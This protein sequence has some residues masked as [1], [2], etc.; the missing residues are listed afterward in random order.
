MTNEITM[1]SEIDYDCEDFNSSK[2]P[3]MTSKV[4]EEMQR[5]QTT[6]GSKVLCK[7]CGKLLQDNCGTSHLKRHLVICPKRPKPVGVVTQDPMSPAYLRDSGLSKALMVRPLKVEPQSQVI[8]FSPTPNYGTGAVT[9]ASIDNA[10]NSIVELNHKNSPT[11]F[12][13]SL[14]SRQNQEELSLDDDVEMKAFYASLDV[15]TSFKSPSQDT[16]VITESSNTTTPSEETSKALKT[17]QDLLSKDFSVLLQTKQCGAMKSTIEYLSK[18]S[19]VK[20]IS[21]EMKLLILEV[22]REFTRWSCDYNNASKKIESASSNITKADKLEESLEANKNEF[23]E[24]LSLENEL[25]NQLA[26]LEQRKKELEDQINAIKANI[27]VFQSA[28]FTAAKR[29]RE[30]F[31]EAKTLKAQRDELREQ[32]PQLKDEREMAKKIQENIQVEWLKLGEKFNKRLNGVNSE[33]IQA[34]SSENNR[35]EF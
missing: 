30:V 6:E 25:C 27:S 8:C 33:Y 1:S 11:L 32:V 31:E 28:K 7:Y 17:L 10:S 5:I 13:P 34:C 18:M 2:R 24:V 3:K 9:I 21:S 14:E 15:E 12:L 23:K 26:T 29:K 22:S 16:T 4:W 35:T 20:G 19:S